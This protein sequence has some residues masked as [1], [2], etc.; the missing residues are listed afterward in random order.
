MTYLKLAG[1]PRTIV[2]NAVVP[3]NNLI[4][5][6]AQMFWFRALFVFSVLFI[7]PFDPEWYTRFLNSRS[8]FWYLSSLTGNRPNLY[9]VAGESGRWGIASYA[10]WGIAAL[11]AIAA[12]GIWT[13]LSRKLEKNRTNYNKLYYWTK[14]AIRYRIAIGL[15]AFGFLKVYPMQMPYPS[16]SNFL[17]DFGEYN[18]YKI[19]WQHVGVTLW[20]EVVLGWIEVIGGVLMFFRATTFVGALINASVLF[21][22]AH[23]NFAYDGGVHVYSSFFVLFS[24]II[25]VPYFIDLWKLFVQQKEVV[26]IEYVPERSTRKQ[27]LVYYS[28]KFSFIL[29]FTVVYGALRY[30]VHYVE[31]FWKEPSTPGLT[32]TAGYYHVTSFELNGKELPYDPTDSIRWNDVVFERWST[33]VYRV[34]KAFPVSLNN[35][36]PNLK[37]LDRNYEL[38]GIAGG[39]RF[40]HYEADTVRHEL[41]LWDK[42]KKREGDEEGARGGL[43]NRAKASVA[44]G[45]DAQRAGKKKEPKPLYVWRYEQQG[46]NRIV[47]SGKMEDNNFIR[48]TL[49]K[50]DR[51]FPIEARRLD[52]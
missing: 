41:K 28:L 48:V 31:K 49:D 12:A 16:I 46:S 27:R 43:F 47:L 33:L 36:T 50:V 9:Q 20:Y 11:I 19:Y 17:T 21:N 4:W 2:R 45:N 29:L 7:V 5:T 15:I 10:T 51:K 18:S 35:G 14:V 34:N 8:F 6:A 37:Q 32:G 26:P 1:T 24:L 38:A 40:L 42:N 44:A 25:L 22:I 39:R 52:D 3:Q 30:E 23:A 13:L